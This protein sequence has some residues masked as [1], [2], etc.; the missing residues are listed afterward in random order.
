MDIAQHHKHGVAGKKSCDAVFLSN[1][2]IRGMARHQK[3][4]RGSFIFII[5][6]AARGEE[7][8]MHRLIA[9]THVKTKV[10]KLETTRENGIESS[11]P[12]LDLNIIKFN[13]SALLSE[14][15]DYRGIKK[16]FCIFTCMT[17]SERTR[18]NYE[19]WNEIS[20]ARVWYV[21]SGRA[22]ERTKPRGQLLIPRLFLL[23][24]CALA[25]RRNMDG[26]IV[27]TRF[28]L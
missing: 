28:K 9:Y 20:S 8:E 4:L 14:T 15:A 3:E 24:V 1:K 5:A 12:E 13:N 25:A 16:S 27:L 17:K 22:S 26:G 2:S 21:E 7:K 23:V 6:A 19:P 10:K 18:S 11:A